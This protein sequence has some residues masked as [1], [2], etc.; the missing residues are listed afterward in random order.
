MLWIIGMM[1]SGKSTVGTAVAS[2]LGLDF[3]DTDLLVASVTESSIADLWSHE[4]EDS[5]RQLEG[6]MIAS[7]AAGEPVVVATGGGVILDPAN[8]EAMRTSGLVVWLTA[9]PET[10]AQRIGRDANRPLLGQAEDP[11]ERLA[12]LLTERSARY[13]QAAHTTV[14]TDGKSVESVVEEVLRAW[15]AS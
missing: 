10:L 13:R 1:G 5:F 9:S 14:A 8:I 4:G 6:Q 2:R 11:R 15:N 3:V 7:A 12:D